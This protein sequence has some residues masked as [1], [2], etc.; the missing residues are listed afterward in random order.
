MQGIPAA[1][2]VSVMQWLF[3]WLGVEG[4]WVLAVMG[5]VVGV[6]GLMVVGVLLIS[7]KG[8][9]AG[10]QYIFYKT[11]GKASSAAINPPRNK[12]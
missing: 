12:F 10:W 1:G 11:P 5:V 7:T 4:G 8:H 3:G 6:V 2:P 9:R